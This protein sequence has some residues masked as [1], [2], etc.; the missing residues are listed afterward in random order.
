MSC[1]IIPAATAAAT[2]KTTVKSPYVF[3]KVTPHPS[4]PYALIIPD[5]YQLLADHLAWSRGIHGINS[6]D[7]REAMRE[8]TGDTSSSDDETEESCVE[9]ED[10]AT[11]GFVRG[12]GELDYETDDKADDEEDPTDDEDEMTIEE[13]IA[14]EDRPGHKA[15]MMAFMEFYRQQRL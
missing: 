8:V 2:P 10:A 5:F 11:M 3:T 14:Q 7:E 15:M 12:E 13:M 6:E 9:E 4:N 1:T